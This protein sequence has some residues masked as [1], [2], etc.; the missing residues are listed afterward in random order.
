MTTPAFHYLDLKKLKSGLFSFW[1]W[2]VDELKA[3]VPEKV[4]RH[5]TK[6]KSFLEIEYGS[7]NIVMK[8]QAPDHPISE[9]KTP[10]TGLLNSVKITLGNSFV[11]K[12][13]ISLPLAHRKSLKQILTLQL[14]RH[15]PLDGD[16]VYFSY[17]TGREDTKKQTLAVTLYILKPSAVEQV[18]EFVKSN[19]IFA[20]EILFL[21]R[22]GPE[23]IR[24]DVAVPKA[25]KRKKP[26]LELIKSP[27]YLT[28]GF[29][30]LMFLGYPFYLGVEQARIQEQVSEIQAELSQTA[31]T[32]VAF[33]AQARKDQALTKVLQQPGILLILN[34]LARVLPKEAWVEDFSKDGAEIILTGFH[35]DPSVIV[36][37]LENS[38]LFHDVRLPSV[39]EIS[40]QGQ[41]G[42]RFRISLKIETS[43]EGGK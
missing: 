17:S 25:F 40:G 19:R 38:P 21:F 14:D 32:L 11:F 18:L 39:T 6:G 5:L 31:S 16:H 12:R 15:C 1:T 4:K 36:A 3:F 23:N 13:K 37:A 28:L 27:I 26:L 22:S 8:Y 43:G 24:F 20:N 34:D 7:K 42:S 10:P 41:Q 9:V 29:W 35:P 30:I 2:W 33:E